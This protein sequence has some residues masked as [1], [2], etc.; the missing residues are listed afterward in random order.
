MILL[1]RVISV[2]QILPWIFFFS[3][4]GPARGTYCQV[5]MLAGAGAGIVASF[6]AF[7]A[8]QLL[9]TAAILN[10]LGILS[11]CLLVLPFTDP[12]GL[13][14]LIAS[15]LILIILVPPL[16]NAILL[17][18]MAFAAPEQKP[19]GVTMEPADG[20]RARSRHSFVPYFKLSLLI[21][22]ALAAGVLAVYFGRPVVA[23][24]KSGGYVGLRPDSHGWNVAVALQR[25]QIHD[26]D[27]APLRE[28]F[29]VHE[30]DLNSSAVTDDGLIYLEGLK[31]LR[32]LTLQGT[33]INGSGLVHIKGLKNLDDLDLSFTEVSDDAL[34]NLEGLDKLFG[35]DLNETKVTDAGLAH[36]KGLKHLG[37]LFLGGTKVGDA[38]L[39]HLKD[40]QELMTLSMGDTLITD[41]GLKHLRGLKSLLSVNGSGTKVTE[42]GAVDL[43]KALPKVTVSYGPPGRLKFTD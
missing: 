29:K 22:V 32:A 41:E 10:L 18:A 30:L 36:L 12:N 23:I 25:S 13:A 33:K 20:G 4:D 39:A 31:D 38:G 27:L 16:I 2:L 6:A 3:F 34:A 11:F 19:T 9:C 17:F 24:R 7:R 37:H 42:K 21:V 43:K 1:L 14:L 26:A 35:L 15:G 8:K 40:L 28:L 5:T